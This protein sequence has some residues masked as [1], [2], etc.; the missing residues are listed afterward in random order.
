MTAAPAAKQARA[1]AAI[2]SGSFGTCG[3]VSFVVT[4]LIA[5]SMITG[6][7]STFGNIAD[8]TEGER[9]SV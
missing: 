3:L 1:S 4:P 5:A 9:G 6:P 7:L 2:S 8:A